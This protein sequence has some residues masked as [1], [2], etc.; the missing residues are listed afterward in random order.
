AKRAENEGKQELVDIKSIISRPEGIRFFKRLM[1]LGKVFQTTFTGNSQTYF[2]EGHRNLALMIF[3][4]I[5]D[6]A[7]DKIADLLVDKDEEKG[8]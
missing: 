1:V 7:P 2:L 3:H 8:G 4:D 5:V 6:A